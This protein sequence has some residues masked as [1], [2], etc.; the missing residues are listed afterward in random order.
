ME[1]VDMRDLESRAVMAWEFESPP[2]H[3]FTTQ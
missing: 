3:Q 2:G 1:S